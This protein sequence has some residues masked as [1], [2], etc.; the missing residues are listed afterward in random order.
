M[1]LYEPER[2]AVDR[3]KKAM[4]RSAAASKRRAADAIEQ[5]LKHALKQALYDYRFN[6]WQ[7]ARLVAAYEYA[8]E[9]TA[10]E[11]FN[12]LWTEQERLGGF[13]AK[14]LDPPII[15]TEKS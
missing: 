6:V 3:I 1:T 9:H 14:R 15:V 2:E 7:S 4:E 12:R 5:E 8:A 10:L 11:T 13:K